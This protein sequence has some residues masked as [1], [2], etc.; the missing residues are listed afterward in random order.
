LK[1]N[2]RRENGLVPTSSV[3]VASKE[4][5]SCDFNGESV[6]LNF[7]NDSYYGLNPVGSFVWSLI[8]VPMTFSQIKEAVSAQYEV[9]PSECERDLLELL[10][11]L[12]D[13]ELI[14]VSEEDIK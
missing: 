11:D 9:D 1:I 14:L 4:Q 7:K 10:N 3:L 5:V 13:N 12:R 8:Q 2:L 6:I